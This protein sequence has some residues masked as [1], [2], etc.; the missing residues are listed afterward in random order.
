[1]STD[2]EWNLWVQMHQPALRKGSNLEFVAKVLRQIHILDPKYVYPNYSYKF[3]NKFEQEID[4]LIKNE[5]QENLVAIVLADAAFPHTHLTKKK[6]S[7]ITRH[8]DNTG[9]K[10]FVWNC[11]EWKI[12]SSVVINELTCAI[13]KELVLS[14]EQDSQAANQIKAISNSDFHLNKNKKSTFSEDLAASFDPKNFE[15][16][17][18]GLNLDNEI[19]N[20]RLVPDEKN[21]TESISEIGSTSKES[22]KVDASSNLNEKI[23]ADATS[24][25]MPHQMNR[26]TVDYSSTSDKMGNFS[27]TV[28][29]TQPRWKLLKTLGTVICIVLALGYISKTNI[30]KE[31]EKYSSSQTVSLPPEEKIE[32]SPIGSDERYWCVVNGIR[33]HALLKTVETDEAIRHV[34]HMSEL[35]ADICSRIY[36]V[37]DLK[38]ELAQTPQKVFDD[39]S[40]N[41]QKEALRL[42]QM[43]YRQDVNT[44]NDNI[45]M[46]TKSATSSSSVRSHGYKPTN[47]KVDAK[48]CFENQL[49]LN[50]LEPLVK[51][52]SAQWKQ[53]KDLH[54]SICFP[55]FTKDDYEFEKSRA[56]QAKIKRIVSDAQYEAQRLNRSVDYQASTNKR[57]MK[58]TKAVSTPTTTKSYGYKPT[59]KK[60]DTKWCFE[61]Q[62]RLD[63]LEPI[64]ITASGL[65]RWQQMKD[66]HTNICSPG[67][68]KSD[69]K[70]EKSRASEIRIQQIINDAYSEAKHLNKMIN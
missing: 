26:N 3:Q 46:K 57:S 14:D 16:N 9:G 37:E 40:T 52:D 61:N 23:N 63:T 43:G 64:L 6:L 29:T 49:R 48:W 42:N 59:N 44:Q 30:F 60:V 2:K 5:N 56:S 4:F 7:I 32:I 27:S 11:D 19:H 21:K 36:T 10:L 34:K 20:D 15:T 31:E 12:D 39:V 45:S 65:K 18:N 17:L 13:N 8:L 53:M 1:M 28:E 22:I 70:F 62:L 66:L 67:F 47:K 51:K 58:E 25:D 50:T 69:F 24:S 68:S 33:L 41:A 35:W 54:A 55:D 38:K